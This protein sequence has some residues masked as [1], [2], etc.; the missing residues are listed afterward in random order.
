MTGYLPV[1]G[2]RSSDAFFTS[3]AMDP[4]TSV[5]MQKWTIDENYI[6]T[7]GIRLLKGRNLSPDFPS[8]SNAVIINE[9]AAKLLATDDLINKHLYRIKGFADGVSSHT[10]IG[11][12]KN[13]N[14]NSLRDM[15]TPL[16]LRLGNDKNSM[17]VRIKSPDIAATLTQIKNKWES[18][19]PAD[20]FT[21]SF[22]DEEFNKLY[23]S[24][25]RTGKIFFTFAALA[26]LI[27]CLGLFGLTAYAATQR[28]REI[29][30]RKVLGATTGNITLMLSGNFLKL[31]LIAAIIAFPVAGWAMHTW[32]EGFAYRVAITGWIFFASGMIALLIAMLTVSYHAINAARAN[33]VT[34]LRAE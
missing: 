4:K 11:V 2:D 9:A 10:I 33:P 1:N 16:V 20:P 18:I 19:T 14:F 17:A 15:I 23:L 29:G 7:L 24:E 13:F 25:Q 34:S 5:I 22:L 32:L 8:D 3:P 28:T 26:I 12:V 6:P 31:V 27:A 30:I 21:Y